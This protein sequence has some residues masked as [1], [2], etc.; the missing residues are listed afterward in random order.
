MENRLKGRRLG[1]EFYERP[2]LRIAKEILGKIFVRRIGG[3]IVAGRIVEVEA[4]RQE[5]DFAS[6]SSRGKTARNEVMFRRGGYL[7]VYFTYGMHFC[8]NVVT[9]GKDFGAALL[10]RAMEPL[11]GIDRMRKNRGGNK[12]LREL[13]SGPAKCCEA[14]GIGREQN[15]TDLL[16][17]DIFLLDAP[18]LANTRIGLS[19]RIGIRRSTELPWRFFEKENPFVSR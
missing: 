13:A 15:G 14:F 4:Y 17:D 10:I 1:R 12:A 7:Y 6:H 18:P 16:G 3:K 19:G 8:M 2:T 11:A 9:E 5:G